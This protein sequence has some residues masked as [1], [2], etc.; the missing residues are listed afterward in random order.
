MKGVEDGED[1]EDVGN[2]VGTA[3]AGRTGEVD[4]L[5]FAAG[6]VDGLEGAEDG[7]NVDFHFAY[8]LDEIPGEKETVPWGVYP[9]K[10]DDCLYIRWNGGG[11]YGDPLDR[12]P[13]AVRR[14]IVEGVV[15][16]EAARN[17]Y[18]IVLSGAD[19]DTAATA[20][21]RKALIEDRISQ[22]AAE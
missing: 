2:A 21:R 9:L 6:G 1:I 16:A 5:R 19:V 8:S 10:G 15:S 14:D 18:G 17:V 22:E 3:G 4:V 20:D 12:D 7:K 13:D 11:G